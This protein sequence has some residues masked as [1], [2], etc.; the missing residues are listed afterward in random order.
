MSLEIKIVD[1]KLLL[2]QYIYLCET[3]YKKVSRWVP[4]FYQDE[5]DFHDPQKNRALSHC[6]TIRAIAL[7]NGNPVGRIMGII[8]H[9]YNQLHNEKTARFFHF[10]CVQDEAVAHLLLRF[11][12]DWAREKGMD[13]LIGPFGFSDKDPQGLQV[14]GFS[15]LPVLATPANPSYL[16]TFLMNE[17]YTK[18]IDC[19]S[20]KMEIP[21]S[22]PALYDKIN[23]RLEQK[24]NVRLVEFTSKKKL[25]PFI[26]P[27]LQLVNE[28]YASLFGFSSMNEEEMKKL[29]EQYLP[30]LDP[31]FVKVI[32]N[33]SNKV[34]AFV[35]GMPDMSAGIQKAKG[36]LLPI[37][38]IHVLLAMRKSKQLNLMLGAIAENYRGNGLTAMLGKALITTALRR[39]MK[40]MDSHLILETNQPMRGEC[41]KI[42]GQ[43]Y[44]RFRIFRK[45]L[46]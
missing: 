29:A 21:A 2:K 44:K 17:G 27:V 38:F 26:L 19:V 32:V 43:V 5:W 45:P 6:D 40:V 25:K 4:P 10:D 14:E 7:K 42:G 41:E 18:E 13:K 23:H 24:N 9:P 20:Y 22:V 8:H 15:H 11:I 34:I 12:E 35:V 3:I 28:A 36:R 33:N 31:E 30:V 46:T 39:G 1:S 16:P 37:G